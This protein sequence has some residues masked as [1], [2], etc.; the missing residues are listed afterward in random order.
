MNTPNPLLPQGT[1]PP[2]GRSGLYFKILMI[3]AV[4]IIVLGGILMVGCKDTSKVSS[5]SRTDLASDPG[6]MSPSSPDLS[7]PP[8]TG[9]VA[10]P[11]GAGGLTTPIPPV[12]QTPAA[13]V[14]VTPTTVTPTTP[15]LPAAT[16][17]AP[18]A[19]EAS[20]YVIASGDTLDA[21]HKKFGVSIKAIEDANP[22]IDPKKLQITHTLNIPASTPASTPAATATGPA[23]AATDTGPAAS[24]ET[25]TYVVKSGDVLLKIA[26]EHG[27]TVRA[28][29]ALNNM[30]T[31]AIQAGHT[32]KV[33][34]T[35]VASAEA[36]PA[37]PAAPVIP[38][39]TPAAATPVR[40][41]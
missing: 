4:H 17:P 9:P 40:T 31:S 35:R 2:P 39:G 24:S 30:K 3:F 22:G 26:K 21:L 20:V 23:R 6:P 10:M 12:P 38:A 19:R 15:T 36:P 28:L 34:V 18:A 33:P 14:A 41:Y 11:P 7:A 27:T 37:S 16:T 32:L 13:S 29:E 8:P 25:T 5:G 1:L